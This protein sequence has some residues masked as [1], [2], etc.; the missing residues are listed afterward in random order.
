MEFNRFDVSTKELIWDDPAAWL[1]RLGI[2][3]PGRI[4]VIDSAITTLTAAADKVIRVQGEFPYLVV[5]EPHSYHDV[6]LVETLWFRQAALFHRHRLPVL[7]VSQ[8]RRC[9]VW[10]HASPSGSM[11]N[12]IVGQRSSGRRHTCLWGYASRNRSRRSYWKEWK[13]C[14]NRPP[15]RRS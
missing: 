14:G 4:D 11:P 13:T 6:D 12:R 2:G 10:C 7:T 15:I 1:D 5:I 3:P 8:K 9:P